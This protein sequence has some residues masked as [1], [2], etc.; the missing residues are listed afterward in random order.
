MILFCFYFTNTT[1]VYKNKKIPVKS[2][3]CH[4]LL[5]DRNIFPGLLADKL[6]YEVGQGQEFC[7]W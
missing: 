6:V 5:R 3:R 1:S 4:L 2:T 7:H